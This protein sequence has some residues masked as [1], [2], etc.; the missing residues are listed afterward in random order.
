MR[1]GM[2]KPTKMSERRAPPDSNVGARRVPT[3]NGEEETMPRVQK[4]I[5]KTEKTPTVRVKRTR[6]ATD[7]LQTASVT[8]VEISR[9]AYQIYESRRGNG[10]SPLDDWLAAGRAVG[11]AAAPAGG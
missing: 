10:G 7:Q 11:K 4:K 9:L 8:E 3:S 2:R 1:E 6:R 5:E